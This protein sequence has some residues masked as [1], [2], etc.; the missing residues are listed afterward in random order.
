MRRPL[1][2]TGRQYHFLQND[3][4]RPPA[5][6]VWGIP[7]SVLADLARFRRVRLWQGRYDRIEVSE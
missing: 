1:G 5:A 7:T 4:N 3:R 2:D 6:V